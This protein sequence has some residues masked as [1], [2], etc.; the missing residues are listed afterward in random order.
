M[1][2]PTGLHTGLGMPACLLT[3]G[4]PPHERSCTSPGPANLD[5]SCLGLLGIVS[6]GPQPSPASCW[7][8]KEECSLIFLTALLLTE[9]LA[10][11]LYVHSALAPRPPCTL[12]VA[13][14]SL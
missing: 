2:Q 11:V 14:T 9:E 1:W 6:Q 12:A 7:L 8:L 5:W 13:A 10:M 3:P 4:E